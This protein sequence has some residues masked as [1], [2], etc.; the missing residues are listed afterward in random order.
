MNKVFLYIALSFCL[1]T[2]LYAKD[3][4]KCDFIIYNECIM[5]DYPLSFRVGVYD[6]C[7]SRCPNRTTNSIGAGTGVNFS[8]SCVLKDCPIDRPFRTDVGSCFVD[9][10]QAKDEDAESNLKYEIDDVEDYIGVFQT[11]DS[12]EK[13]PEDMPLKDF[14]GVCHSCF[15]D[16]LI[17]T[18]SDCNLNNCG[19]ECPNRVQLLRT[20]GNS[21]SIL[22]CPDDRPL[23]DDNA[24]CHKCDEE[25]AIFVYFNGEQC[26]KSCPNTRSFNKGW[27]LKK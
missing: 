18:D 7:T 27:C 14:N 6:E 16:R 19:K 13:C 5:C 11:E 3:L 9:I 25:G 10:E 24:I 22:K 1:I 2:E 21:P 17:R 26:E 23:M 4:S 20:G 15:D 8:Y 12:L